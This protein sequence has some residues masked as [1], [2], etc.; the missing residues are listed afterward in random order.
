MLEPQIM[1]NL[2]QQACVAVE[3]VGYGYCVHLNVVA[4][5]LPSDRVT[6]IKIIPKATSSTKLPGRSRQAY[7]S[8]KKREARIRSGLVVFIFTSFLSLMR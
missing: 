1:V 2:S 7:R 8:R 3:F 4:T 5:A 6:A